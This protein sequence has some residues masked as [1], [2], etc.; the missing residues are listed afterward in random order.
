MPL[1]E[2]L[3]ELNFILI[4]LR[5]I[6]V[7]MEDKDLTMILLAFLPPSYKNFV[8]PLSVDKNSF[9][10]SLYSRELQLKAYGNGDE[11][12]TSRLLVNDFAKRRKKNKGKG[13]KKSKGWP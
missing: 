8:S 6:D 9:T 10:L 11:A 7:K 12:S 1:K 2:H 13:G 3:D 4:E 5:D